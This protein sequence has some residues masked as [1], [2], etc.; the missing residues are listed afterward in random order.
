MSDRLQMVVGLA[1]DPAYKNVALILK[2]G[3]PPCVR[4]NWNGIG[5]KID[6]GETPV[7]AMAREFHEETGVA[8]SEDYWR[9]FAVLHADNYD[10][11]FFVADSDSVTCCRTM[12]QERVQLFPVEEA[13][14]IINLMHN[15]RWMIPFLCDREIEHDLGELRIHR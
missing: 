14:R 8:L 15:I 7:Q 5:G 9:Q 1:F 13:I 10:L 3:G 12:E 4:G 11:F 2:Q 6:P